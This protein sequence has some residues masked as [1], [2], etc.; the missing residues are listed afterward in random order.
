[1][2]A[3]NEVHISMTWGTEEHLGSRGEP[4]GSM[5]GQVYAT[6]VSL[7]LDDPPREQPAGA[8]MHQSLSE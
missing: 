8:S 3:V 5:A 7:G 1:V 6:Q 4:L 2:H